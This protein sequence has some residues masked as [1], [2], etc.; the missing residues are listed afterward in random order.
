MKGRDSAHKISRVLCVV[1]GKTWILCQRGPVC[2][3]KGNRKRVSIWP[4]TETWSSFFLFDGLWW[5]TNKSG[6]ADSQPDKPAGHVLQR[7]D[8]YF[9]NKNWLGYFSDFHL[10]W[11]WF[12][13]RPKVVASPRAKKKQDRQLSPQNH[14]PSLCFL[15]FW[16]VLVNHQ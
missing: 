12:R 10:V 6:W 8:I 3:K 5:T 16:R 7:K 2:P 4:L 13:R 14:L 11:S 1:H 15:S 9:W